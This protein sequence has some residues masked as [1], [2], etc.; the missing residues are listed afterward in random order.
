MLGAAMVGAGMLGLVSGVARAAEPLPWQM[1]LQPPATPIEERI[2]SLHD[3][4]MWIIVL[5]V[6]FVMALLAYVCVKFSAKRNPIPSKTSHNTVIEIAWTVVPVLIL[7]V[8]AIP[9]FKLMYFSERVPDSQLTLKVT[10]LQWYWHYQYPDNG[11][12]QFDS[13]G[14]DEKNLAPGQKRLLDVDNQVVLPVNTNIRVQIA[15]Q[16]V[17]HSWFIP[18]FG[19]QKYAVV[20]R[21]NETW[22]NIEK[23]GIYYGECN[24]ICGV[25]HSFMPIVIKAVTKPEFDAWVAEAKT[26]FAATSAPA[27]TRLAAASSN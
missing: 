7:L 3:L 8:I 16:D 12:F 10:G 2:H 14:I 24:Q 26:K 9:S 25:N 19:V 4:L 6:L 18:S 1:Y 20:G 11:D 5:I 21:L 27:A 23:P 17:M 15:G 22:L 13:Y